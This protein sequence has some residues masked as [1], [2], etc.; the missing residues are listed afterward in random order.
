LCWQPGESKTSQ[1]VKDFEQPKVG[2]VSRIAGCKSTDT[3][4]VKCVRKPEINELAAGEIDL[5]YIVPDATHYGSALNDLP[6]RVFAQPAAYLGGFDGAI[7][8]GENRLVA[9][10]EVEFY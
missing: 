7:R 6:T 5:D 10:E 8:T 3:G 2:E 9:N 4:G 1:G